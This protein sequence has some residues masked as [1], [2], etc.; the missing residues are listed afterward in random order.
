MLGASTIFLVR[1]PRYVCGFS[2][3]A[4]HNLEYAWVCVDGRCHT[5]AFR[6]AWRF[7][8]VFRFATPALPTSPP[9]GDLPAH[10]SVIAH[11]SVSLPPSGAPPIGVSP[12]PVCWWIFAC[13][14]TQLRI[15]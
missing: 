10:L 8:G 2:R 13:G 5:R 1:L 11:L 4:K 6:L 12:S 9:F 7:S 15:C 14:E 3:A